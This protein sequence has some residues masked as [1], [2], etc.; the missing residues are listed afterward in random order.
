[1]PRISR[2]ALPFLANAKRSIGWQPSCAMSTCA[3]DKSR[4]QRR[5]RSDA[6]FRAREETLERGRS[7]RREERDARAKRE[8]VRRGRR[9]RARGVRTERGASD[10]SVGKR[11]VDVAKSRTIDGRFTS[12]RAQPRSG[13]FAEGDR[14]VRIGEARRAGRSRRSRESWLLMLEGRRGPDRRGRL[15]R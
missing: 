10:V 11:A 7:R 13:D 6:S 2:K 3:L 12:T 1:M 8:D 4:D 14:G 15:A 5:R 9:R